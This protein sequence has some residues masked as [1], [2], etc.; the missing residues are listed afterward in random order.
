MLYAQLRPRQSNEEMAV[1]NASRLA[2][3]RSPAAMQRA[4]ESTLKK[5]VAVQ[6]PDTVA[7]LSNLLYCLLRPDINS[8]VSTLDALCHPFV[9]HPVLPPD[10]YQLTRDDG[11]YLFPAGAAPEGSPWGALPNWLLKYVR[12]KGLGCFAVDD[13][14]AS[15]ENPAALYCALDFHAGNG[16]DIIEWQPCRASVSIN[17]DGT[18]L[19]IGEVPMAILRERRSPGVYFNA[20]TRKTNNLWLDRTRAWRDGKGLIYI[21]MFATRDIKKGE[22]GLWSYRYKQGQGANYSFDDSKFQVE[23]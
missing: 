16:E 22:E 4:L 9:T 3:T 18:Q 2:A 13:I 17:S 11:G 5:G 1:Y 19:A 8:R 10:I 15:E 20:G 6:Q 12:G 7:D 21:P 14:A 23:P